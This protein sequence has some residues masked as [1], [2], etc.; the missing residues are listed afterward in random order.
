MAPPDDFW[1]EIRRAIDAATR[2]AFI[3]LQREYPGERFYVVGLCGSWD[4]RSVHLIA[5]SLE[6]LI[7]RQELPDDAEPELEW[8]PGSW[9]FFD[10]VDK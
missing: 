5:N 2:R 7:R 3:G 8:D 1:V 4:G 6:E 10:K 9:P